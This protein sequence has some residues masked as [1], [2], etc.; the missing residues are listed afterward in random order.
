[1]T[2][3]TALVVACASVATAA[4]VSAGADSPW[5][6][7]LSHIPDTKAMRSQVLL[8]DYGAAKESVDVEGGGSARDELARLTLD[9]GL[10]PSDLVQTVG[11]DGDAL[12]EELGIPVIDIER[13]VTAG[14]PPDTILVLEGGVDR[15]AI[16]E[17]TADD[18]TWSDLRRE[19]RA[20]GQEYYAWDGEQLHPDRITPVRGLGR[21]GRL[22]VDPPVAVWT[23]T[24]AAMKASLTASAGDTKSLAENADVRAV[25]GALEDA[26]A[27]GMALTDVPPSP[28]ADTGGPQPL[29]EPELVAVGAAA[30]DGDPQVIV[31]LQQA[32]AA[33]AE[34]NA[35]R[36]RAIAE[37]G[38][39]IVARRPWSEL[40]SID[41]ITTD[42]DLV[43]AT[44][45]T[46]STRLWYQAVLTRDSL[47]ATE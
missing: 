23:N 28:G 8:S 41:D 17:A 15:D 35:T 19:R 5:L 13:E 20:S 42:G 12:R 21:G 24:D 18:R 2:A 47:L 16:D 27:Y 38:A 7:L 44:F 26:D 43:V 31:V 11:R 6:K 40:L 30:R 45:G 22:A 39:S 32:S 4:P 1:M 9:A 25:V 37:Q 10:T 46:E 34:E 3:A 29:L 14:A 36:L 33:D